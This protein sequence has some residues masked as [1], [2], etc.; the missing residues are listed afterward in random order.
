[1]YFAYP[2]FDLVNEILSRLWAV[3]VHRF[4]H[5]LVVDAEVYAA[6]GA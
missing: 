3:V 6:A 1:M 4:E 2:A 5:R